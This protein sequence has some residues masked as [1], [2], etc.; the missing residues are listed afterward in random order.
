MKRILLLLVLVFSL[1]GVSA[2]TV[3]LGKMSEES[4]K[5]YLV[6]LSKE[7]IN[8]FGPG[9]SRDFDPVIELIK[10]EIFKGKDIE[11]REYY[12]VTFP[13]DKTKERLEWSFSARVKI[14]KDTGEPF[15]VMF[16]NGV[17]QTFFHLS[18][19]EWVKA[20]I[21]EDEQIKYQQATPLVIL[22]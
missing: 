12:R 10:N 16:G 19:K 8:N 3:E 15:A 13:Y 14:W 7:V 11:D 5:E 17:G 21:I 22:K 20:G 1:M 2:Q 18:Y 6:K 9:Y 4:R